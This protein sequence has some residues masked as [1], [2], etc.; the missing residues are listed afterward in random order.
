[1]SGPPEMI[2][3]EYRKILIPHDGTEMSDQ[4]LMYAI[5]LSLI[6]KGDVIIL[7]VIEEEFVPPSFL[8]AFLD[9]KG[10]EAS[11]QKLRDTFEASIRQSLEGKIKLCKERG[12]QDVSYLIKIGKPADSIIDTV[13]DINADIVIM[14]SSRISSSIKVLGSNTRKVVDN[15]RKPIM[16]IHE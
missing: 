6:S 2:I 13:N 3:H 12:V 15:I 11:K 9:E 1:M 7:S 16:I 14:A 8:L 4:A 10:I 5:S